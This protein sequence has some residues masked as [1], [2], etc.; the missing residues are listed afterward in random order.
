MSL[1]LHTLRA[2][3]EMKNGN[4][5]NQP[6][7]S[8]FGAPVTP[9]LVLGGF[10]NAKYSQAQAIIM[11]FVVKNNNDGEQNK[12]AEA[13]ERVFLDYLK[14]WKANEAWKQNLNIEY[15]SERSILDEITR[16]SESD[17]G[18]IAISYV[19]MFLYIAFGLGQYKSVSRLMVSVLLTSFIFP[20]KVMQCNTQKVDI[21]IAR[22]QKY[23]SRAYYHHCCH[24]FAA[25]TKDIFTSFILSF[26][27]YSEK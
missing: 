20:N 16:A 25:T 1:F 17:V 27:G 10:A 15:S 4:Y 9:E 23:T 6:C 13:W 22:N 19:L 12:K 18:T 21:T 2:P 8:S 26:F 14:S 5:R 3:T 11:T 24:F 7:M